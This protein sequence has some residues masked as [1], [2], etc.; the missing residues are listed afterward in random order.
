M[1]PNNSTATRDRL[2]I[3]SSND[4][5]KSRREVK[6]VA[7][8]SKEYKELSCRDFKADCDFM[9]RAET[10]DEVVN[11]CQQHACNSHGKCA[12]SSESREKIKSHIR[13]VWV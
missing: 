11:Y 3:T 9:V 2:A 4:Y 13:S 10:A 8:D 7:F 5:L 12:S 1:A 6:T